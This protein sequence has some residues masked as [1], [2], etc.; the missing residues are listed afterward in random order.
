MDKSPTSTARTPARK[1][2]AAVALAGL[3]GLGFLA[4]ACGGAPAA[5]AVAHIGTTTTTVAAGG[6][7][8]S[9]PAGSPAVLGSRLE[10]Y[11]ACM[12]S[13]GVAN[14]PDPIVAGKQVSLIL[15]PSIAGSPRFK[16]AQAAC[17]RLLPGRQTGAGFTTQ[18][19]ADYLKA[20]ACMRSHGIAGF[21]DPNISGGSVTFPLPPGMNSKAPAFEAAREICQKLIPQGLPYSN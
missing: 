11:S 18:Q 20:A 2:M 8:G 12:R 17:Q 3:A 5:N 14:F 7:G 15:T 16:P 9:G 13:H 6:G 4:T 21:P 19:Q 10:K 1:L